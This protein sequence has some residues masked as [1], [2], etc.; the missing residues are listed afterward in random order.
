MIK[1]H[2]YSGFIQ[3]WKLLFGYSGRDGKFPPRINFKWLDK[4][5]QIKLRYTQYLWLK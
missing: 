4:N 5:N 3:V 2:K 1:I